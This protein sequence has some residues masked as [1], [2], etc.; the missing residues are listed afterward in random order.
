M[1]GHS[2]SA[3]AAAAAGA[4]AAGVA[5]PASL[6]TALMHSACADALSHRAD[7]EG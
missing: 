3:A 4:G 2:A 7:V 5:S 1:R 6:S